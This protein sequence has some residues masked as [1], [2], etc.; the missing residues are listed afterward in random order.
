MGIELNVGY[1]FAAIR[2]DGGHPSAAIADPKSFAGCV[3]TD[4]VGVV[5]QIDD[6][7]RIERRRIEEPHRAVRIVSDRQPIE[8]GGQGNSLRRL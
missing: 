8:V 2:I 6:M 4:V 7:N 5:L 1:H 3:I